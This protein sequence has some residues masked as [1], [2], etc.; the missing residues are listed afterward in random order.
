M[1]ISSEYTASDLKREARGLVKGRG[2]FDGYS[3]VIRDDRVS[4]RAYFIPRERRGVPQRA[5][6][7]VSIAI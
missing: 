5:R 1:T 6:Q 3:V 4:L 7:F 2:R